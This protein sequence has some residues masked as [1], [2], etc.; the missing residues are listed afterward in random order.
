V[1]EG[2]REQGVEVE[3]HAHDAPEGDVA[4]S[5]AAHAE[6]EGADLIVLCTHGSGGVPELLYGSI[7]QRV[8]HR[9]AKPV[10]LIRPDWADSASS[11]FAD[12]RVLVPL[13]ATSSAELAIEPAAEIAGL[14]GASLHLVMVVGTR[15]S[16]RRGGLP[17][18]GM[19]P[20]ATRAALEIES[21]DAESYLE[22]VATRVRTPSL[23]VTKE[24]RHGDATSALVE[25]AAE[26]GVALVVIATRG[27]AGLQAVW[28][29]SVTA[30]LLARTR[31]P[32]LL[33]RRV[34]G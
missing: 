12:G 16:M 21:L 7:A 29:G 32:V 20:S 33:L 4:R 22:E 27:R 23:R 31:A 34:E 26:P 10:L 18:S 24:V 5:V 30:Q 1:A 3:L 15:E 14:L 8:L 25:E 28:A 2:L 9:G 6:E 13:D 19:L 17:T 11:P